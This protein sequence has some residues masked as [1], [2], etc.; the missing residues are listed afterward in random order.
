MIINCLESLPDYLV[1]ITRVKYGHSYFLK[2]GT[3]ISTNSL[4]Q[5]N[6]LSW[7]SGKISLQL[8]KICGG[9]Y[10]AISF[11]LR[12]LFFNPVREPRVLTGV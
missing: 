12:L 3:S 11:F 6:I 2:I 7:L 4:N 5:Y 8:C 1:Y 10:F 9:K